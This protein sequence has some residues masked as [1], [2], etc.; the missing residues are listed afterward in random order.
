MLESLD[1]LEAL[2]MLGAEVVVMGDFNADL[3][4]LAHINSSTSTNLMHLLLPM[5]VMRIQH[6]PL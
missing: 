2:L 1:Q 4:N 5:K 6:Y 3:G